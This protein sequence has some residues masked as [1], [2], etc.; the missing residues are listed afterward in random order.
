LLAIILVLS[1]LAFNALFPMGTYFATRYFGLASMAE[2][3]ATQFFI[4]NLFV[5]LG[6]PLFGWIHDTTHSYNAVFII[7]AVLNLVV[8]AVWLLLPPYRFAKNIGQAP[9]PAKAA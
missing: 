1:A 2:I 4:T 3:V 6:A 9:A 7:T 8:A 5:G